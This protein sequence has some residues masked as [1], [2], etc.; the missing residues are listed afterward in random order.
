MSINNGG[1]GEL[2]FFLQRASYNTGIADSAFDPPGAAE[3]LDVKAMLRD[4]SVN[5]DKLE[6]RFT[7]YSL[8]PEGNFPRDKRQRRT[9]EGNGQG[10]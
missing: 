2:T 8:H 6:Q 5:Q 7:E 3:A 1:T 4:V 9:K 10:V